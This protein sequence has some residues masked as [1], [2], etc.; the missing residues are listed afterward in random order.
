MR[1]HTLNAIRY[2]LILA[3][4]LVLLPIGYAYAFWNNNDNTDNLSDSQSGVFSPGYLNAAK[5]HAYEVLKQQNPTNGWWDRLVDTIKN[6]VSSQVE[7]DANTQAAVDLKKK[8]SSAQST[9]LSLK[10]TV[11]IPTN[12][13]PGDIP[14]YIRNKVQDYMNDRGIGIGQSPQIKSADGKYY[15]QW[16]NGPGISVQ[17]FDSNGIA[18]STPPVTIDALNPS[19]VEIAALSNGNL[20]VCWNDPSPDW[21]N[22]YAKLQMIDPDGR[23]VG[24]ETTLNTCW[25]TNTSITA[26]S[27]G[28]LA[29]LWGEY[30]WGESPGYALKCQMMDSTGGRL[31]SETTLSGTYTYNV[32]DINVAALSNGNVAVFWNDWNSQDN[33]HS[34]KLQIMNPNGGKVGAED[35]PPVDIGGTMSNDDPGINVTTLSNGNLAVMWKDL[36][37]SGLY[38]VNYQVVGTDGER[39]GSAAAI[40]ETSNISWN[41]SVTPL[42]NGKFAISWSDY[43]PDSGYLLKYEIVGSNGAALSG[44]TIHDNATMGIAD[45]TELSDGRLALFWNE[46]LNGGFSFQFEIIDPNDSTHNGPLTPITANSALNPEVDVLSNGNLAVVWYDYDSNNHY[47]L[48]SQM[49]GPAGNLLFGSPTPVITVNMNSDYLQDINLA[50]LSNGDT[51][52]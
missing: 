42:S 13:N 20:A 29:V 24:T 46:S 22:Y 5:Q 11:T 7:Q 16:I 37:P 48:R 6:K 45:V 41:S 30:L 52:G 39:V 32:N 31:G 25:V 51:L 35:A 2:T 44:G 38:S 33:S 21:S 4:L 14:A 15:A 10:N 1:S 43:N 3:A 49:I 26:L 18:L 50:T 28:N 17:V 23:L 40:S 8:T 36:E 9:A 27:N 12:T 19:G 34:I 47:T